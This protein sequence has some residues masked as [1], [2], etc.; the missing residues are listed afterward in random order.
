[1]QAGVPRH[2]FGTE[3]GSRSVEGI[4]VNTPV[5]RDTRDK[6]LHVHSMLRELK[7]IVEAER[8]DMLAHLIE[9][10]C[11]ESADMLRGS[12]PVRSSTCHW[13]S[14]IRIASDRGK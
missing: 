2:R 8:C 13:P 7:T 5:G 3:N 6:L 1:M 14:G 12:R 9:M 10:A 11:L 4:K